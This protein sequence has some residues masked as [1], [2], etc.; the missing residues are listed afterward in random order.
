MSVK[1]SPTFEAES[2]V[3]GLG[4]RRIAGIDEVGRGCLAGPVVAASVV[5]PMSLSPVFTALID[6]SKKL[7][8]RQRERANEA[9]LQEAVSVGIGACDA[10]DV[11]SLGIAAATKSAMRKA[12]NAGGS[13]TDYLLVDAVSD[14]GA[15]QPQQA[16]IKGDSKSLSIAAASIVAKVYRDQLMS[17]TCDDRYPEYGFASHKGYGTAQHM[18]AL[19]RHG[20]TPIHRKSFSPVAQTIASNERATR[21][22]DGAG[23]R[24]TAGNCL[25]GRRGESLAASELAAAGYTIVGRNRRTS[26]GEIDVVAIEN[27]E[28]V[29]VEV[30]T[31]RDKPKADLLRTMGCTP[32]DCMN[33]RKIRQAF[34][35][36][37]AYIG[38]YGSHGLDDWRIDF[39]GVELGNRYGP[40]RFKIIQNVEPV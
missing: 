2:A 31:C 27:G 19:Q 39:V 9:I 29:F 26:C 1:H 13:D 35:C 5:L 7:A 32:V 11:D 8:P 14:I 18:T 34:R 3:Y 16:I 36:A 15:A 4:Y 40:P 30:K 24:N 20:A 12:V 17:T 33:T 37:E 6:D 10:A 25:T 22:S 28:V 21:N 23:G 38:E